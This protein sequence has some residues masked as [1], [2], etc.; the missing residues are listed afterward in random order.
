MNGYPSLSEAYK[1]GGQ[2]E[3]LEVS[4]AEEARRRYAHRQVVPTHFGICLPEEEEEKEKE[5]FEFGADFEVANLKEEKTRN[6]RQFHWFLDEKPLK[7][8]GSWM[9]VGLDQLEQI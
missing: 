5:R 2:I 4:P 1:G 3:A 9:R 8:E 6:G 7:V